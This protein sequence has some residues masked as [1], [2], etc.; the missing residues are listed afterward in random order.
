MSTESSLG[1]SSRQASTSAIQRGIFALPLGLPQQQ[2]SVCLARMNE[3]VAWQC[4]AE[5][6]LQL[7]ILPALMGS[8]NGAM[9]TIGLLSG[10]DSMNHG[11][12][13]PTLPPIELLALHDAGSDES[14]TYYFRTTYDKTVL[15]SDKDFGFAQKGLALRQN[16]APLP[17]DSFWQCNFNE[18]LIEGYIYTSKSSQADYITTKPNTSNTTTPT[19]IPTIP[20]SVKLVEERIPNGRT[21]Y[22][23]KMVVGRDTTLSPQ[24]E[25]FTLALSNP[26]ADAAASA[27]KLMARIK[28]QKRLQEDSDHCRCQWLTR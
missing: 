19:R 21:P 26:A 20:Y 27:S 18:T 23:E 24:A 3:S 25:R 12:R 2:S 7:S 5:T 14:P 28:Y 16:T 9:I 11:E 17:G 4:A 1:D 13:I 10:N 6:T 8:N 22:C 15:L